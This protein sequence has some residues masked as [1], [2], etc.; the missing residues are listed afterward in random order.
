MSPAD[1]WS[2]RCS[3]RI[4]HLPAVL[5]GQRFGSAITAP[6]SMSL[7]AG[8]SQRVSRPQAAPERTGRKRLQR[9]I[10]TLSER[11]RAILT[12]LDRLHFLT[13]SHLQFLHFHDHQTEGAAARICR[14]TLARLA[15]YRLIRHL[16]RRIG[17]LHAGSAGHVWRLGPVGDRLLRQARGDGGRARPKEPSLRHLDHTLAAADCYLQLVALQRHGHAELLRL[18]PE[19]ACWRRFLG[20]AGNQEILKPDLYA[21]TADIPSGDYEDHWFIEIDRAT[22]SLPTI[23]RKCGQY[24]RYRRSGQEQQGGGVFP[25]VVWLV[26]DAAR[27]ERLR[28]GLH[29]ARGVDG[30]LFRVV[31]P[32]E[33]PAMILG[34]AS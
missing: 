14:R 5:P 16:E 10:T 28:R 4:E 11:D 33:L 20:A 12:D 15:D 19:P 27:L 7:A 21:V 13:T 34:G 30:E 23:V 17:G 9:L 22:E 1:Q 26:P 6:E 29:G 18:E 8:T 3:D 32:T 25:R 24:E 31:V 2:G